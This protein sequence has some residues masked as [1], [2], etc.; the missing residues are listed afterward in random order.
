MRI[1]KIPINQIKYQHS[2]YLPILKESISRIGLSF[3][4]KVII[5]DS[6]YICHDGHKRLTILKELHIE[7][8]P[9]I[10]IDGQHN[11]S[12]DCWRQRNQ[13]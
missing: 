3:P 10:I 6:H 5:N 11:R 9:C 2:T 7:E 1:V 4:I 12:N 13:H 8:V